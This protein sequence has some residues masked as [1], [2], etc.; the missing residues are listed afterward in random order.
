MTIILLGISGLPDVPAAIPT[1]HIRIVLAD[2]N[3]CFRSR[4]RVRFDTWCWYRDGSTRC[5]FSQIQV[6]SQVHNYEKQ[7]PVML[8]NHGADEMPGIL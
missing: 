7:T 1:V 5:I 2:L 8:P 4:Y 6:Y 3:R